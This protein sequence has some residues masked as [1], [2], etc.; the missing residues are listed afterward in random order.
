MGANT[1]K[2]P[3]RTL[4]PPVFMRPWVPTPQRRIQILQETLAGAPSPIPPCIAY[5]RQVHGSITRV[6]Y[7]PVDVEHVFSAFAPTSDQDKTKVNAVLRSV[8]VKA[9]DSLDVANLY[10]PR[11]T[12]IG[13]LDMASY[14]EPGGG[15]RRG[16][17][18]QEEDMC[19]RTDLL[20][21]L[22]VADSRGLYPIPLYSMLYVPGV[23]ILRHSESSGFGWVNPAWVTTV[24]V[25]VAPALC[26]SAH[27]P[28]SP[29]ERAIMAN[30]I[31]LMFVVARLQNVRVLV[32]GAFGC[33]AYGNPPEEVAELFAA[34]LQECAHWFD[35]VVFAVLITK[36]TE[37][38]NFN[39]F[40][41]VFSFWLPS[42]AIAP[43]EG[44]SA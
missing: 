25:L 30:K 22:E 36:D 12:K 39:A 31:R 27:G 17:K 1:S 37:R 41:D 7:T 3:Q 26:R 29:E 44:E 18:A 4:S 33:G 8:S 2:K 11:S 34:I 21:S 16:A 43:G 35:R 20:P 15:A 32:L 5:S 19:R 38:A 10:G 9:M 13:V 6:G 24:D 28:W 14:Q 40:S 23:S 42:R